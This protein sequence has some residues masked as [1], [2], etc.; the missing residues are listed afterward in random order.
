MTL[1]YVCTGA[2]AYI[3]SGSPAIQDVKVLVA[4]VRVL[5]TEFV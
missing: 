4:F 1:L 3:E 2:N 5:L